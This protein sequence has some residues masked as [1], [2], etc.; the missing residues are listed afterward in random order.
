MRN[1]RIQNS[2]VTSMAFLCILSL[3]ASVGGLTV[4]SEKQ[5]LPYVIADLMDK[6]VDK[7]LSTGDLQNILGRGTAISSTK[8]QIKSQFS[9]SK[10]I[11]I[12]HD[13]GL[14]QSIEILGISGISSKI[15]LDTL[16]TKTKHKTSL[17]RT[18]PNG[19]G[20]IGLIFKVLSKE[21]EC[22][23]II[24]VPAGNN[25]DIYGPDTFTLDCYYE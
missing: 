9:N 4:H 15:F 14:M 18:V 24:N 5:K 7:P 20:E 3:K 10:S 8:I 2:L 12:Y 16:K 22:R 23:L 13:G 6:M 17:R 25:P 19:A 1:Y 21:N 11:I